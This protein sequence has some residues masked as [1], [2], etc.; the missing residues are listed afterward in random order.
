MVPSAHTPPLGAPQGTER[1]SHLPRS[2][3]RVRGGGDGHTYKD[4][5][6]RPCLRDR[7]VDPRVL[8]RLP[9]VP[10]WGTRA[11]LSHWGQAWAV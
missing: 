4:V 9:E 3:L 6:A 2:P 11:S 5:G 10:I 7:G 1:T 8:E